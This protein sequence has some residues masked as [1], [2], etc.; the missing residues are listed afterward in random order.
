MM[1]KNTLGGNM[2]TFA[3]PTPSPIDERVEWLF[4]EMKYN[5]K[6]FKI[7]VDENFVKEM[8]KQWLMESCG[9]VWSSD[10][11]IND[12]IE[13]MKMLADMSKDQQDA[14]KNMCHEWGPMTLKEGRFAI[15]L[16]AKTYA[17]QAEGQLN[18]VIDNHPS[19]KLIKDPT[20]LKDE[21]KAE[22]KNQLRDAFKEIIKILDKDNKLN[23]EEQSK[24]A[25]ECAEK[26]M[27]KPSMSTL[28][29]IMTDIRQTLGLQMKPTPGQ[30]SRQEE[31]PLNILP[32]PSEIKVSEIPGFVSAKMSLTALA[33]IAT[34][35]DLSA[36]DSTRTQANIA[37]FLETHFP[38]SGDVKALCD[39][40]GIGPENNLPKP[41]PYGTKN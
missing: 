7:D 39:I 28:R 17:A 19:L 33:C 31:D 6:V 40:S 13:T 38:V 25:D 15:Q 41:T 14:L 34:K 11:T 27:A 22:F 21:E 10:V 1:F 36:P 32:P 9:N 20:K 16:I 30:S 26:F 12:A 3:P 24:L 8:M 29:E 18:N 5:A 23:P 35:L 4:K 2:F 37:G